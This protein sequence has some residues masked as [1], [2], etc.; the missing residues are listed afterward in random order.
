M[1]SVNHKN[2]VT[3]CQPIH[4]FEYMSMESKQ[5]PYEYGIPYRHGDAR[6]HMEILRVWVLTYTH[7]LIL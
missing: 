7:I 6:T 3:K 5:S 1:S 2:F 4:F